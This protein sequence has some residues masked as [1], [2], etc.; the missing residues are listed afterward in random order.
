MCIHLIR[1][2]PMCTKEEW[3]DYLTMILFEKSYTMLK[4]PFRSFL[5]FAFISENKFSSSPPKN[6][7]PHSWWGCF[8]FVAEWGGFEPPVRG[9][10][11]DS[12]ANCSFRPLR[13]HSSI[14]NALNSF[15]LFL[16]PDPPRRN[17]GTLRHLLK[18][19]NANLKKKR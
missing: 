16:S 13:H 15:K 11:Y 9:K 5:F 19:R 6:K 7:K 14:S 8:C 10:A 3:R 2:T 1:F 17:I 12:L 4:Q 18:N